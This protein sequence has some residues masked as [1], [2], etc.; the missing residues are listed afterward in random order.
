LT[1]PEERDKTLFLLSEEYLLR[2]RFYE[3]RKSRILEPQKSQRSLSG[4]LFL[5]GGLLKR[6][7]FQ[8]P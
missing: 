1:K 7:V 4:V 2:K 8:F 5:F 6:C 3:D